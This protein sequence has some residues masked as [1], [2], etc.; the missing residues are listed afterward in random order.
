M[1]PL[2]L[3]TIAWLGTPAQAQKRWWMEEPMRLVQTNLRETDSALDPVKLA[4]QL[5]TFHA[6]V[7]L[8]GMGGIV[9]HYPTKAPF[10][11][12]SPYIPKG[13]DTFGEVLQQ[14]HARGIRV[15]GRFDFSK[16]Q[17]PVF[18]AHPEWFMKRASGE[19]VIY[20][21]LYSAC[22]NG[23]YYRDHALKILSE[24][25]ETYEVDALFFNMFGNQMS[26]YSGNP[27]GPCHCDACQ[28]RYRAKYGRDLPATADAPYREFLA[29][30]SRE[31][32]AMFADLIHAK[33]PGAGF[34][35]YLQQYTDAI[36]SESNTA[37]SRPLPLW[38]YSASDN[39][40]RARNSEPDKMAINLSMSFVDF[41]WRFVTVPPDE[42]RL[43][44]YQSLA[45]GAG[46]AL[47]MHGTMD[48]QDRSALLAAAPVFEWAAQHEDLY[49]GQRSAAR[50]LLLGSGGSSYRGLFRILSENHVPFAV[51][52]NARRLGEYD[53]VIS[54]GGVPPELD[55][56]LR[57]GG[58]VLLTGPQ[59]PGLD[60]PKMVKRW[61]ETRG[62]FRVRD[63]A[64]LPSLKDTGLLLVDGPY[65]EY[66][67]SGTP[68]L[69]LIPES[70]FGPPEKVHV[71][72][73][74]TTKPGLLAA[75]YGQGKLAFVPWDVGG[76]YYRISSPGHSGLVV[77]LVDRLLANGRQLITNAHPLVETTVMAQPAR[78]RTLVHLVNLSGH[79]QTGYFTPVEMRGVEFQVKGQFAGA[80]W[81]RTGI[82]LPVLF[83]DGY[84]RF[85]LPSLADYDV[86][87]LE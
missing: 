58:R 28:T 17:K 4:N 13:H 46:L 81:V 47:N 70:M 52:D 75:D 2:L 53:L 55:R 36:M 69:T 30:S 37:V 48:Q 49:V 32:A 76:L 41:P 38:P 71:D 51:S 15:I 24:A 59:Q 10:H 54:A 67:A 65:L 6:N 39:V 18:E 9:A 82:R 8:F 57:D 22:I 86:I 85:V 56:Y 27:I 29:E 78:R 87:V 23:G 16:A 19:P 84:T 26:D 64:L 68:P 3:V 33:R 11:Y 7:L 34:F 42:I 74:E 35:T 60:L 50:V 14:A 1:T 66:E 20:N 80:L 79:S 61:P 73:V 43:R 40:D 62:Y 5:Q 77:D 83:A 25:L 12:P 44:L 63:H 21:G 31:V 72:A 45:H